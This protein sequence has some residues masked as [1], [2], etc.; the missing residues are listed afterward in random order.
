M[1]AVML[2]YFLKQCKDFILKFSISVSFFSQKIIF[3]LIHC[4]TCFFSLKVDVLVRLLANNKLSQIQV[5]CLFPS[6]SYFD[7]HAFHEFQ[8]TLSNY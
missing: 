7:S 6:V 2:I 8:R 1:T 5:R 4:N 3:E